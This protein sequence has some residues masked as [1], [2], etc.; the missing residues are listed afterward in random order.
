MQIL[1]TGR[2]FSG[3]A[4]QRLNWDFDWARYAALRKDCHTDYRRDCHKDF[5]W[6]YHKDFR[7]DYNIVVGGY[8]LLFLRAKWLPSPQ[9]F[10]CE[11]RK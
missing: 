4:E 3:A 7:I 5:R 8:T 9:Y 10:G 11:E 1:Q 2:R 6:V